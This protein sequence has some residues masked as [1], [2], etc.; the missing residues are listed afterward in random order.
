MPIQLSMLML[1]AGDVL[2][3]YVVPAVSSQH[4]LVG[5]VILNEKIL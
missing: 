2:S 1:V 4:K 5:A 3:K